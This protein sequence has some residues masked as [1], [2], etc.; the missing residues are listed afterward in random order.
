M[1]ESSIMRDPSEPRLL[2]ILLDGI[3]NKRR[4]DAIFDIS[5]YQYEQQ[6]PGGSGR[7]PFPIGEP[8]V[9]PPDKA[10]LARMGVAAERWKLHLEAGQSKRLDEAK[11][12]LQ[13]VENYQLYR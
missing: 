7:F 10:L 11:R 5:N 8:F 9:V 3:D 2:P 4:Q 12:A 13:A 1:A 6:P